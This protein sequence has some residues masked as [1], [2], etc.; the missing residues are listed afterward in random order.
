MH[1]VLP[2]GIVLFAVSGCWVAGITG[3]IRTRVLAYSGCVAAVS[4]IIFIV[5]LKPCGESLPDRPSVC[6][7]DA[8]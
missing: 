1:L 8:C 3:S 7:D 5:G 6:T 2:L 4:G